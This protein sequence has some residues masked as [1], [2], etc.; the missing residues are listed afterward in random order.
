MN[1]FRSYLENRG[2]QLSQTTEFLPFYALPYVP[3]PVTHPS[4]KELFEEHWSPDLQL[5]MERFIT[6]ALEKPRLSRLQELYQNAVNLRVRLTKRQCHLCVFKEPNRL[7]HFVFRIAVIWTCKH[8]R[9]RSSR[10]R[11]ERC[12]TCVVTTRFNLII[13]T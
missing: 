2:S 8:Y 12:N 6:L 13:I 10:R 7:F 5:R 4:F 1:A 9:L 3:D 11:K